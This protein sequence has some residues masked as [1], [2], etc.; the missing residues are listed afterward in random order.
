MDVLIRELYGRD[1]HNDFLETLAH[2]AEINLSVEEAKAIFRTRLGNGIRTYVALEYD[3][4]IGTISLLVEQKFI[5]GGGHVGHI[6]DVA[7]HPA[8]VGR[9]IGSALVRH[10]IEQARQWGCYKLILNCFDDRVVFYER[11]GFR[12]YDVGMRLDLKHP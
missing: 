2:L 11:L 4:V 10:V 5:H 12:R 1:F 9:G 3:R 6:E 7:V 8:Y